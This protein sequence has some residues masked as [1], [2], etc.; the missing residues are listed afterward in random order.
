M[1]YEDTINEIF[2]A[3]RSN[4][5]GAVVGTMF[6]I[7]KS[8]HFTN[9]GVTVAD[10]KKV[11]KDYAPNHALAL[12]LFKSDI[13]ELKI[14]AVYVDDPQKVTHE[15]MRLWSEAFISRDILENCCSMLFYKSIDALTVAYEWLDSHP[16]ATLLL[17]SRRASLLY[18]PA[19]SALYIDIIQRI[20]P[21]DKEDKYFSLKCRLLGT[22]KRQD[23]YMRDYV[24]SLPLSS[25]AVEEI[26]WSE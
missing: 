22:L 25:D 20:V 13:R 16:Y 3:I 21:F 1:N 24:N 12:E 15:Q 5:N 19:E 4:M 14:C 17:A 8:E 7:L 18:Y 9:Y 11:A 2:Y 26:Q 10:V 23:G 6:D